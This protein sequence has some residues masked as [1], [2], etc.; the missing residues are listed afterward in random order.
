MCV[1]GGV[2]IG[3][4][5]LDYGEIRTIE[6]GRVCVRI[7]REFILVCVRIGVFSVACVLA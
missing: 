7:A 2:E 5:S 1:E 6:K 3:E 4:K